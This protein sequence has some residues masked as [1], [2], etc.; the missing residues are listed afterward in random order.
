MG[1]TS[2]RSGRI[3]VARFIKDASGSNLLWLFSFFDRSTLW[4]L[5]LK[6]SSCCSIYFYWIRFFLPLWKKCRFLFS[7]I[8][9]GRLWES[10]KVG[11]DVFSKLLVPC[12]DAAP[13]SF[14]L[15]VRNFLALHMVMPFIVTILLAFVIMPLGD[16]SVWRRS[17][18]FCFVFWARLWVWAPTAKPNQESTGKMATDAFVLVFP[19]VSSDI[20]IHVYRKFATSV[21]LLWSEKFW[22]WSSDDTLCMGHL[23]PCGLL[24][25]YWTFWVLFALL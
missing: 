3:S 6:V 13:S 12:V 21:F 24:T 14:W 20:N 15:K 1:G 5:M 16:R 23:L 18:V 25:V 19:F 4:N 17:S 2:F 10:R 8:D 11:G 7:F 22:P 9:G